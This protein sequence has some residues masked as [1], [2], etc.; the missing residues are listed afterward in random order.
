MGS[1]GPNARPP[2][3]IFQ[4]LA[5][6]PLMTVWENVAFGLEARGVDKRARRKRADELLELVALTGQATK[7]PSEL[8]GGQ[9][10]RVAIAR[11]LAVEP[12]V[13][14]LDEPLSALDLKLRQHMRAELRAIQR[15]TG[16]T[17]IY[18]THD[19]GEAL[20]MSDRVAVMKDGVVEQ[21]GGGDEV[22]GRPATPFVAS[23]VGETNVFQGTV[24]ALENDMA[25]V[26]TALGRMLGRNPRGLAPGDDAMVF[27]RPEHVGL[28]NGQA[29]PFANRLTAEVERRDLEGPFVN[30]F[31][32]ASGREIAMHLTNT[33]DAGRAL[34]GPQT[35][36][37]ACEN[38]IVLP[39]GPL[40]KTGKDMVEHD[41]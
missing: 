5:L 24:A 18:I 40:A 28:A 33:G 26:D 38:A 37:F 20:T 41:A 14:L 1:R 30:V 19:Q 4:N 35:V 21:V 29:V 10:Q 6:F 3:L 31:L 32:N 36:G 23:F 27:V 9:R 12:A 16:I 34:T 2:A 25:S 39:V 7:R 11:A 8:S 17:F 22:Y 15:K 13:L